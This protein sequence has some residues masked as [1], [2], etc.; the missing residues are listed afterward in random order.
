[1]KNE[2]KDDKGSKNYENKNPEKDG[3]NSNYYKQ[4]NNYNNNFRK[5]IDYSFLFSFYLGLIKKIIKNKIISE[6]I[7]EKLVTL[8]KET[9]YQ[10]IVMIDKFDSNEKLLELTYLNNFGI[11]P[12]IHKQLKI[13]LESN[14]SEN[15]EKFN[16]LL[17]NLELKKLLI[18]YKYSR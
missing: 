7:S 16:N 6:K 17:K 9:I 8:P 1:M 13:I 18:I 14:S 4:K 3:R 5:D 11:D 2:I 12:Y 15:E 10:I